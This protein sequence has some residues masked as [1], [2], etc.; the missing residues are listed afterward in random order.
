MLGGDYRLL[1][2]VRL[3]RLVPLAFF[4]G[5]IDFNQA[6]RLALDIVDIVCVSVAIVSSCLTCVNNQKK[7]IELIIPL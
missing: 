3:V 6:L 2:L 1:R 4:F 5:L 7:I